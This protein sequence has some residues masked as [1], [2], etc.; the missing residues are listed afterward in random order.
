MTLA[1]HR[2]NGFY[3][4]RSKVPRSLLP[5][6]WNLFHIHRPLPS[7]IRRDNSL[8]LDLV[9]QLGV[10]ADA[11]AL[12]MLP[13]HLFQ[14]GF[15]KLG[16]AE[17]CCTGHVEH[18]DIGECVVCS[19]ESGWNVAERLEWVLAVRQRIQDDGENEEEEVS[20]QKQSIM[21]L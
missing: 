5:H 3:I 6:L 12:D 20:V 18:A 10:L 16:V 14:Y 19:H 9:P 4:T 17:D 13:L 15:A 8:L 7:S 21:P 2:L 1:R 11:I